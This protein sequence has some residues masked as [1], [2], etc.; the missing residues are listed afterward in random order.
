MKKAAPTMNHQVENL[1]A[2]FPTPRLV[3]ADQASIER[4]RAERHVILSRY[5]R[6]DQFVHFLDRR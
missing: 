2:L 1:A 4:P 3:R 5:D 6:I